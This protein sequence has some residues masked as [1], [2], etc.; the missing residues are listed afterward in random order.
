[1][2]GMTQFVIWNTTKSRY[3]APPGRE[4][5]FTNSI[6]TARKFPTRKAAESECCGNEYVKEDQA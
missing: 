4:S 6:R 5:S 1:M 3:V 2:G